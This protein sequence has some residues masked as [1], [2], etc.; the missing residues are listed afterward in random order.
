VKLR[1]RPQPPAAHGGAGRTSIDLSASLN[2]LGPHPEALAAARSAELGRYPEPGGTSLAAAAGAR[3]GLPAD[4]I[5]PVP[6]AAWGL[7]LCAVA[8]LAP[9]ERCLGLAPCFEEVRRSVEAVG[10][11]WE[12]V[13]DWPPDP[14]RQ[15]A[16]LEA[17]L[18]RR[19][20]ACVVANPGNPSG[21]ALPGPELR[22]LCRRHP[23]TRFVVDEAFASFAP[24]GT[25]LLEEGPPPGNA[26]VVR[27][28]TKELALPGLRMGYLAA[29]PRTAEGLAGV[30][31]AWPLSAPALAAA[32]AGLADPAHVAAGAGVA[33]RHVQLLG[34]ALHAAGADP[35]PSDANFLAARAP[36]AVEGL[37]RR[38]VTVRDCASFGLEGWVR[39]AAPSPADL[40]AVLAAIGELPNDG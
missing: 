17:A 37:R 36:G 15:L 16:A 1:L 14:D 31:P 34:E 35:G 30:L 28:L 27:S 23:A 8:L 3:H 4:A 39:L 33:W 25:S 6:G 12:E 9:G 38:G 7:W 2:P 11:G 26:V 21:V 22:R 13:R 24:A 40:P 10:A 29:E 5:V 20:A 32:A 18:H 19:P